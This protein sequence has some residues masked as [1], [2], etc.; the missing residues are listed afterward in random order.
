MK[1]ITDIFEPVLFADDSS[2]LVRKSSPTEFIND[3]NE[4]FVNINA[5]VKINLLLL[6]NFG[7]TCYLHFRTKNSHKIN[8]YISH[9][10]K[11]LE[12]T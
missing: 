6:L 12:L 11:F 4:V 8:T 7:R 9:G 2:I 10:N 1:I 3:I 5:W